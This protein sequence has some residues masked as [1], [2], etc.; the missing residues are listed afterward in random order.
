MYGDG[1]AISSH[2]MQYAQ[3]LVCPL[4]RR[5][6]DEDHGSLSEETCLLLSIGANHPASCGSVFNPA[7]ST[8]QN[9]QPALEPSE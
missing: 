6:R 3:I 2:R 1:L 4:S 5:F 8:V 9:T 7:V